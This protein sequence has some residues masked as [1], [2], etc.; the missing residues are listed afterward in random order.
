MI[1]LRASRGN[2]KP[3]ENAFE[4]LLAHQKLQR[5]VSTIENL[6][7]C[8][9]LEEHTLFFL[10]FFQ[11][12]YYFASDEVHSHWRHLEDPKIQGLLRLLKS[13]DLQQ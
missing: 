13:A 5:L 3:K 8:L 10:I 6:L 11:N 12:S 4:G 2:K 9:S 1:K 7:D